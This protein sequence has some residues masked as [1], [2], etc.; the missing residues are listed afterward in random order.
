M[1]LDPFKHD[2]PF[3]VAPPYQAPGEVEPPEPE[4]VSEAEAVAQAIRALS[5]GEGAFGYSAADL[6][7][8]LLDALL[9]ARPTRELLLSIL[10]PVAHRVSTNNTIKRLQGRCYDLA[11]DEVAH[12]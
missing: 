1:A 8:V 3:R 9:G 6:P 11:N 12:A 10:A 5:S 7:E 2:D 4:E